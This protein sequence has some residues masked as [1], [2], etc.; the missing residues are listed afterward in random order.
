MNDNTTIPPEDEPPENEKV[1]SFL[2]FKNKPPPEKDASSTV[3]GSGASSGKHGNFPQAEPSKMRRYLI[4][5]VDGDTIDM[6]GYVGLTGSFLAIG[7][8]EGRIKFGAAA[9]VWLIVTDVTDKDQTEI[10]AL[11]DGFPDGV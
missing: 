6:W 5:L 7:D 10:D 1:V 8:E 9:G 3:L 2:D 4:D 11:L